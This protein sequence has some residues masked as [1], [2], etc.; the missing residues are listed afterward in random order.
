MEKEL[1]EMAAQW[2]QTDLEYIQK[3]DKGSRSEMVSQMLYA[4]AEM[5]QWRVKQIRVE[6]RHVQKCD[7]DFNPLET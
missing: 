1:L 6:S 3:S 5:L 7:A 4:C 2:K